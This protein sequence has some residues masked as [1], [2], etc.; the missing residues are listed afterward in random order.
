M[1][2]V[3][4]RWRLNRRVFLYS[5]KKL[6][7]VKIRWKLYLTRVHGIHLFDEVINLYYGKNY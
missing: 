2:G 5:A 1:F 4:L 6:K 3:N 7:R